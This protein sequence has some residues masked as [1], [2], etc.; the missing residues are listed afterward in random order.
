MIEIYKDWNFPDTQ[1][2][3]ERTEKKQI[4]LHHT[5]SGDSVNGDMSWWLHTKERVATA[6]VISREGHLHRCFDDAYWAYHLGLSNPHFAK[7]GISYRKLDP[8]T[9]GIELDSWGALVQH[10][11]GKFY[12]V[13]TQNGKVVPNLKCKAV[14]NIYEYC[15][16]QK[17]RGFQYFERYTTA[18]LETLKRL[19]HHLMEAHH[20]AANFKS[21]IWNVTPRAL[22]GWEGVFAHASYR[23]DKSDVHPQIEL[24]NLLKA[25]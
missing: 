19:L 12:P 17:Y 5:V 6:Y 24:V 16:S 10:T 25:L 1:Y 22:M 21:D 14:P 4:V 13:T 7:F 18:Q 9:I 15:T 2:V 20:I 3:R 11:D 8:H 23:Q